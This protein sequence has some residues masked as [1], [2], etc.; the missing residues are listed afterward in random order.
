MRRGIPSS[1]AMCIGKKP[2]LKPTSTTQNVRRP[3][4]SFIIRPVNFG[5]QYVTPPSTGNT[6]MPSST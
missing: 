6:L 1:P 4:R 2:R 3:K 5:N